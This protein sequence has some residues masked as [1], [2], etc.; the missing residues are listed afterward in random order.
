ME[1]RRV[2]GV[3]LDA[4]LLR[5]RAR[6]AYRVSRSMEIRILSSVPEA[7]MASLRELG[8][9]FTAVVREV[10]PQRV[11]LLL[12]NGYE[13]H[14]E[15]RLSRPV[16]EGERLLLSV[17]SRE[18]L[19]LR[20]ESGTLSTGIR[21][22]W[23]RILKEGVSF[24]R[25]VP[26]RFR[27]SV[28]RSGIFYERRVWEFLRGSLE[29]GEVEKDTKFL[30]LKNLSSADT[31]RMEEV[32]RSYRLPQDLEEKK[33]KLLGLLR[34]GDKVD[35][36]LGAEELSKELERRISLLEGRIRKIRSSV[37]GRVTTLIGKLL[38][39]LRNLGVNASLKEKILRS[40]SG[41]PRSL[42]L[43]RSAV[44][45]IKMNRW[46]EAVE[47]L[48]ILGVELKA[49]DSLP[50]VKGELL[51]QLTPL[52]SGAVQ[53]LLEDTGSKDV[54][55]LIENLKGM[56]KELEKLKSLKE[57]IEKAVPKGAKEDLEKLELLGH[58]QSFMVSKEGRRFLIPFRT[59]EGRGFLLFALKDVYRII[60]KLSFEEGFFGVIMEAPKVKDPS[61]INLSFSTDIP[62]LG[63]EVERRREDL[64]RE[65]K[66]IGLEVGR[67]EVKKLKEE[68]FEEELGEETSFTLRV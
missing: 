3:F 28:E 43:L 56:Q 50:L 22:L 16:A 68:G 4:T 29:R 17:Q 23:R 64:V 52:V 2:E 37:E 49:W 47:K 27:E 9:R 33:E 46:G 6:E 7:L 8:S 62:Y 25:L 59:E 15:N 48:R 66:E 67:F 30:I 19:V 57:A 65:L 54:R 24:I 18:P 53:G 61:R 26:E 34:S 39:V 21:D 10:T 60:I 40:V 44:E 11:V 1:G 51:R 63:E 13:I 20:V 5:D 14:A 55:N 38:Q 35:F 12:E 31:S 41:D 42:D 36:L 58:L 32:L 45:S